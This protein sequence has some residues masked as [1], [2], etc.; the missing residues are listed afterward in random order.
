MV[1]RTMR[2]TLCLVL[3]VNLFAA[4]A[5]ALAPR[6][7]FKE[8]EEPTIELKLKTSSVERPALYEC[9][10]DFWKKV[11]KANPGMFE[12][13]KKVIATYFDDTTAPLRPSGAFRMPLKQGV[14]YDFISGRSVVLL[15]AAPVEIEGI[16]MKELLIKG[17]PFKKSEEGISYYPT[18]DLS[19]KSIEALKQ[20]GSPEFDASGHIS[21]E[22]SPFD[23]KGA[24][25]YKKTQ[26]EYRIGRHCFKNAQAGVK[27]LP[28]MN[29]LY[30][31]ENVHDGMDLGAVIIASPTRT[32]HLWVD[33]SGY[34][35]RN[36]VGHEL[37]N[38]WE[39]WEAKRGTPDFEGQK[40]QVFEASGLLAEGFGQALR[41]FHDSGYTHG[42][43]HS[44]NAIVDRDAQDIHLCDFSEAR[45][46]SG[47]TMAQAFAYQLKD[48]LFL[49]QDMMKALPV[50]ADKDA[51]EF[52]L[53]NL[54]H[55]LMG[56]FGAEAMRSSF[57]SDLALLTAVEELNLV[58]KRV[59]DLPEPETGKMDSPLVLKRVLAAMVYGIVSGKAF[60]ADLREPSR[61][62]VLAQHPEIS[63]TFLAKL[64]AYYHVT[65]DIP[66]AAQQ[67]DAREVRDGEIA[68]LLTVPDIGLV[69]PEWTRD[70]MLG[71]SELPGDS[72][73][74]LMGL[75]AQDARRAILLYLAGLI[76]EKGG[77][78]G[79]APA[80]P[81]E[82]AKKLASAK[83][84]A[85]RAIEGPGFIMADPGVKLGDNFVMWSPEK[86]SPDRPR[87]SSDKRGKSPAEPAAAT[88][89][90]LGRPPLWIQKAAEDIQSQLGA[91]G[92]LEGLR[93]GILGIIRGEP[94][95]AF[96]RLEGSQ[97]SYYECKMACD[98]AKP[99]LQRMDIAFKRFRLKIPLQGPPEIMSQ[100]FRPHDIIA[101]YDGQETWVMDSTH[102]LSDQLLFRPRDMFPKAVWESREE[103]QSQEPDLFLDISRPGAWET[104]EVM[105]GAEEEAARKAGMIPYRHIELSSATMVKKVGTL[106]LHF[107]VQLNAV[108]YVLGLA[109]SESSYDRKAGVIKMRI[110]APVV[111]GPYSE[112]DLI[113]MQRSLAERLNM[114]RL[115][116]VRLAKDLF[117][118]CYYG[119]ALPE[120]RLDKEQR[121]ILGNS[122]AAA[123]I[124]TAI[125][126]RPDDMERVIRE[127]RSMQPQ[128]TP[129]GQPVHVDFTA[130]AA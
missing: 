89:S 94:Y 28:V 24:I 20:S 113:K 103:V 73:E 75:S 67:I 96:F 70:Q 37:H 82:P 1:Q 31:K 8:E 115:E 18:H 65:R 114:N 121:L 16:S 126:T 91:Q 11:E 21:I 80:A 63:L 40:D 122:E 90:P 60:S 62:D 93:G 117:R 101:I 35:Y 9:D 61:P 98:L 43:P 111:W 55:V 15:L 10:D 66:V 52:G 2:V 81:A 3:G 119:R 68:R 45:L 42:N 50:G 77:R 116:A 79:I 57:A 124:L 47:M 6:S 118:R 54:K 36:R 123:Y 83:A 64:K 59:F 19:E 95:L 5:I 87:D 30:T 53:H 41:R 120:D 29:V 109:L 105:P 72:Q 44:G 108:G 97:E 56:Y 128:A 78:S 129:Q 48:I 14:D 23:R 102:Q 110:S 92:V 88:K 34:P 76:A 100:P 13:V 112:T 125:Y 58:F 26:R 46:K 107:T 106:D 104:K 17:A 38:L 25:F 12:R 130:S 7:L 86:P 71:L 69:V 32:K 85:P 99:H 74:K 22:S 49:T 27:I 39:V 84:P 127:W 51:T 4:N 33:P